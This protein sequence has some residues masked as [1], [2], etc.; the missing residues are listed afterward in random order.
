MEICLRFG[1]K[2][3]VI[4]DNQCPKCG[5]FLKFSKNT[6]ITYNGLEEIK[7]TRGVICK[8]CGEVEP[9]LTEN[10]LEGL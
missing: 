1:E 8:R 2:G 5:R 3:F 9:N 10:G 4:Y 6:V 7:A